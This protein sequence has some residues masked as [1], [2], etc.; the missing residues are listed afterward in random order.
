MAGGG[1]AVGNPRDGYLDRLVSRRL[2]PVVTRLLLP[3]AVTPNAVTL[4]GTAIGVAGG[5]LVGSA[6]T[7]GIVAGTVCLLVSGVLDCSDGELA[8]LRGAASRLGHLLDVVG[9]TLVAVALLAGVVRR[10]AHAGHFPGWPAL[11]ALILGVAG[12]FA[13]ITWSEATEERRRRVACWENSALDRVLGP[14]TTRDWYAFP[15]AFALAG[16]LEWLVP[17]AAVGAQ[18]FWL[19]TLALLLRVLRAAQLQGSAARVRQ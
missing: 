1:A 14:L 10:L 11:V 17:A 2:S 8:R 13:V 19:V 9:D 7:A 12:A 16:R 18:V 3:T 4:L 5:L 15:V 6:G